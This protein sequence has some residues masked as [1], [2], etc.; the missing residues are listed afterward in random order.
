MKDPT[1]E[2]LDE[3]GD[4]LVSYTY[5]G[6]PKKPTVVVKDGST[7]IGDDVTG[8]NDEY[9]VIYTNN[10]DAGTA[11]VNI[12]D[13][14]GGNYTVTGSATFVIVKA[15]IVFNPAP[16]AAVITYDG[17]AHELVTPGTTSGGTVQY[18]LNSPNTTFSDA[19]PQADKAGDYV[20]YYKV[21]GDKNHNDL[22][23]Q[24]VP[25]TIARKE[26]TAITIELTPE[27]FVYDGAVHMPTVTVK[28]GKTVLP[29][30]EYTWKCTQSDGTE[31]AAPI[32]QGTYTIEISDATGGNYDLSK[33]AVSDRE[34]TFSIG[35]AAQAELVIGG[36][37]SPTNYGDTFTLSTTG[38]SGTGTVTWSVTGTAA[39]VNASTGAVEI[40]GV[41]EVT[42][43][44]TNPGDQ[45]Y[46][47]VSA[48]WTFT[49]AP[50]PVTAS[51]VVDDKSYDDT[52][53]AAVTSA[54]ITTINGDTVTI[55][56][57]SITA[58]FDTASVGT[59]K[60]VT[61]DTSKVKVSGTDAAKYAIS[62]PSTVTADI[63]QAT[64]SITTAPVKIDPLTYTGQPQKLVTAGESNVG[65]L[66]Y[67]LDGTDFSPEIPAGTDAGTYK[68]YYKVD[69]TAD[70]TGVD[71]NNPP[72]T[73]TIAPKTVTPVIELDELS[74]LY[75]GTKHEPKITVKDGKTVIDEDQYTVT[76]ANDAPAVTTDILTAAGSYTATITNVSGGNYSF[77]AKATVE[78]VPASQAAL[79]ITG[80]PEHVCYGDKITTLSTSGGSGNGTLNWR[81]TAGGANSIINP[82]TGELTVK[83]T[84]SI[85]VKAERTVPNYGTVS[86]TWTFTVEPKPVTAVVTV[87][88]K[89]YD[90]TTTI[91]DGDW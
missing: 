27:S 34:A 33:L 48:Q 72:I 89:D 60:T 50:K 44:A 38:G 52:T 90:G 14:T 67:S 51:I 1:I 30:E 8:E 63:T 87:A 62:Y 25:V 21:I 7:V 61:L 40:T 58:E 81:I 45:N 49:A 82:S 68:V 78:I 17:K 32:N 73:V 69:G 12:T 4:P 75:D 15:N 29:E 76:W 19:I 86:D 2:L 26:L 91:D 71:V 46:E 66:V 37:P 85:T 65:L 13:K 5:D 42:I 56:P 47:S 18:A 74:Y 9:N 43:T 77:T 22:A 41:G 16:K 55:D 3:N 64:T 54:S 23:V 31:V 39:T 88:A 11:T 6:T 53:D 70:Y 24:S 79:N 84:G 57:A 80:Q 36:K 83:D 35:R 28:D 10:V 59:G 20:V